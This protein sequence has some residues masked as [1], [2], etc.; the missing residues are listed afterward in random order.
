MTLRGLAALRHTDVTF[1]ISDNSDDG[2]SASNRDIVS[3]TLSLRKYLLIR[4][5]RVLPMVAHW[6]F[7]LSRAPKGKF[8]GLVTD[9]MT[10]VPDALDLCDEVIDATGD[11]AVSFHSQEVSPRT[12][13]DLP[14][15]PDRIV[16]H[17]L[18]SDDLL[19]DFAASRLRKDSPRFLNSVVARDVVDRIGDRFGAVFGGLSPDYA[20]AFRFLEVARGHHHIAAPLLIDHSPHISNGMAVTRNIGN[21]ANNDF[22]RRAQTEQAADL[23]IGPIP[24]ETR[25]LHNIILRE[26]EVARTALSGPSRFPQIDPA[27]FHRASALDLRRSIQ[28]FDRDSRDLE[29]KIEAYRVRHGLPH[30]DAATRRRNRGVALRNALVRWFGPRKLPGVQRSPAQD[31]DLLHRLIALPRPTID[32]APSQQSP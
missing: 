8:I 28:M 19:A 27:P 12:G 23:A 20:F 9:R 21:A 29:A 13:V 11:S 24:N 17:G 7:A 4:P 30:W 32:Y 22:I 6:T 3:E 14:L 31:L 1:V 18:R 26:M 16:A 25:L 15:W 2:F 5:D 10:L